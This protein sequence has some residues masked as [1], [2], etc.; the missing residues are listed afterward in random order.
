MAY[1]KC[2]YYMISNENILSN[3][4]LNKSACI[5]KFYNPQEGKYY[6]IN[7]ANFIWP[8][9]KHGTSNPNTTTN[10]IIIKK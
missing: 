1:S 4:I 6:D 3:A 10:G 9:L 8:V 2:D 5:K 7:D